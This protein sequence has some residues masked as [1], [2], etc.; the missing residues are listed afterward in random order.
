MQDWLQSL[1]GC[2]CLSGRPAGA[3]R[4]SNRIP[5][6]LKR[7]STRGRATRSAA[8]IRRHHIM[9]PISTNR[10]RG[11]TPAMPVFSLDTRLIAAVQIRAGA[12]C[13]ESAGLLH[14]YFL[15]AEVY[16]EQF[17]RG[18]ARAGAATWT[19][20]QRAELQLRRFLAETV[21][22]APASTIA[23][24]PYVRL[25]S[26]VEAATDVGL[27]GWTNSD[28]RV[29]HSSSARQS[30]RGFALPDADPGRW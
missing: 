12:R 6:G 21:G 13:H 17:A 28:H 25:P 19:M 15:C 23:T 26:S 30:I 16:R 3:G 29:T 1:T 11:Q 14:T 7:R 4:Q 8:S 9:R 2:S 18:L 5:V 20:L 24:A 27:D 22:S 10:R